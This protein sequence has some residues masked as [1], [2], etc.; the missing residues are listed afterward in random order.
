MRTEADFVFEAID[1]EG[2][3]VVLS[4]ATWQVKAGDSEMGSHPE[5]AATSMM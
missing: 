2:M 5:S 3:P 4:R 1:Y